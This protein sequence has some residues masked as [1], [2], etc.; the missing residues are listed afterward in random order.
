MT[1]NEPSSGRS[2]SAGTTP[3]RGVH[4]TLRSLQRGLWL[5][6][7]FALAQPVLAAQSI[8]IREGDTTVVRLSSRDQTR[9][10]VASGRVLEVIGDVFDA[11]TNPG[12]RVVVLRDDSDGEVYLK[13]VPEARSLSGAAAPDK[14]FKLDIKTDRGTVGLL[15]QPADTV[16][17][18]LVLHVQGGAVRSGTGEAETRARSAGHVRSIKALTLALVNPALAPELA[19]QFVPEAREVAL[20]AQARFVLRGHLEAGGLLGQSFE[21]SNVSAEP[22]VI[23]EREL[24]TDGVLSVAV[25]RHVLAPAERTRVWIVRRMPRD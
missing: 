4:A 12:G 23:D 16:G 14:P 1:S 24:F 2:Q 11:Q 3:A 21:L 15:M 18:T 22:M 5:V 25:E 19:D 10:R 9:L 13:P 17:D 7:G 6:L 20:W 8:H